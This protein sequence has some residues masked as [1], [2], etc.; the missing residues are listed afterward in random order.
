MQNLIFEQY[1]LYSQQKETFITRSF[2]INIFYMCL[3]I[4]LLLLVYFTKSYIFAYSIPL[5]ALLSIVG[6]ASSILWWMNMDAYNMLIKI[7]LSKVLEELESQLPV[8]PYSL[9]YD[10]IKEYR[11][12]KKMFLF[13]DIQKT[14]AVVM[15][16]MFFISIVEI[17]IPIIVKSIA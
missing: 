1:K 11:E 12:N 3:N 14:V 10:G 7:K 5:G 9:E 8:K 17:I 4:V 16:L 2:A 15:F 13:S 6:M